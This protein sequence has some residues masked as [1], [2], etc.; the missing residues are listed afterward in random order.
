MLRFLISGAV[1]LALP[2]SAAA[3]I[4]I[5]R[6]WRGHGFS[7]HFASVHPYRT[8]QEERN[9]EPHRTLSTRLPLCRFRGGGSDG[10]PPMALERG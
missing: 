1:T 6:G 3:G 9:S 10:L 7:Y 5:R 8:G 4:P 2:I